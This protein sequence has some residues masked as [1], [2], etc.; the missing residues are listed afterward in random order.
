M[1]RII[2]AEPDDDSLEKVFYTIN[3]GILYIN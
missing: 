3:F 1:V 2:S